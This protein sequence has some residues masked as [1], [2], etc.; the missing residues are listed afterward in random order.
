MLANGI[1][2]V[3][4]VCYEMMQVPA[5]KSRTMRTEKPHVTDLVNLTHIVL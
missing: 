4:V 2:S 1:H 5:Y 3:D